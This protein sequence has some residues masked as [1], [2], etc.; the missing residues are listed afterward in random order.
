MIAFHAYLPPPISGMPHISDLI[1]KQLSPHEK[2]LMLDTNPV[3]GSFKSLANGPNI[4][5][6]SARIMS[7]ICIWLIVLFCKAPQP[8]KAYFAL[9]DGFALGLSAVSILIARTMKYKIW[10]HHHSYRYLDKYSPILS[11]L[12]KLAPDATH[13]VLC[14]IMETKI[15]S[16]Y[17]NIRFTTILNNAFSVKEN[18]KSGEP[19]RR[20][21]LG[22]LSNLSI[23]KG[24]LQVVSVFEKCQNEGL[25]IELKVAGPVKTETILD[26]INYLNRKYPNAFAYCGSLYGKAKKEYY[27]NVNIFLFP[28]FYKAEAQPIVLIEAM[29]S[30]AIP[31]A[32]NTG[33]I[34]YVL[35]KFYLKP[36]NISSFV[37]C[38]VDII[39][40]YITDPSLL[41]SHQA[42]SRKVFLR[43]QSLSLS[44]LKTLTEDILS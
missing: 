5:T 9:D 13:V 37:N 27:G 30:S 40:S 18:F 16:I 39:R 15:R 44:Q 6:Y 42:L 41:Y 3:N 43:L 28:S 1:Y 23:E 36:I 19:N 7:F 17:H 21:V 24:F 14:P 11:V 38:A 34:A 33:G 35:D 4:L 26:K 10:I 20:L 31:I 12:I 22:H 29:A 2:I 25:P 32:S 8:R